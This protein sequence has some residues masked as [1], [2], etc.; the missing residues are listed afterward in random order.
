[1]GFP[2]VQ[3]YVDTLVQ[4]NCRSND[5]SGRG[6]G[7]AAGAVTS[8]QN[9]SVTCTSHCSS[10]TNVT[11]CEVK[12]AGHSWPGS[13]SACPTWG[14]MKCTRDVDATQQAFAFFADKRLPTLA[15]EEAEQVSAKRN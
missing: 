9:G 10:A 7:G 1:M 2:P 11:F 13:A 15:V 6:R 14:P 4:R 5:G 3:E 12:G 8:F